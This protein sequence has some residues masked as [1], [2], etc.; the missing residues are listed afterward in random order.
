MKKFTTYLMALVLAMTATAAFAQDDD[1][2]VIKLGNA[3][4]ELEVGQQYVMQSVLTG[5]YIYPMEGAKEG[6]NLWSSDFALKGMTE[7][8]AQD[9]FVTLEKVDV[10]NLVFNIKFQTS[11]LYLNLGEPDDYSTL[12]ATA[13]QVKLYPIDGT[14]DAFSMSAG[15]GIHNYFFTEE[16]Q[17]TPCQTVNLA[18]EGE[19]ITTLTGFQYKFYLVEYVHQSEIG[20]FPWEFVNTQWVSSD[21]SRLE[22]ENIT[23]NDDNTVTV[24]ANE[25]GQDENGNPIFTN[26]AAL[27]NSA[28]TGITTADYYTT[29]DQQWLVV[30]GKDLSTAM[31]DSYLWWLNGANAGS[32]VPQ[33]YTV[34]LEDGQVLF[35]WDVTKTG[36]DANLKDDRN[37]QDGWTC[38]GL[39]PTTEDGTATFSDISFY[40]WDEAVAKYP[41]LASIEET[42]DDSEPYQFV[43]TD[44]TTSDFARLLE[45]N[46]TY[47]DDNTITAKASVAGYADDGSP[48]YTNNIGLGNSFGRAA[49]SQISTE[50][51]YT[52]IDQNW[53][54]VVGTDLSLTA[55]DSYLWWLNGAN[56]GTQEAAV[57]SITLE[58]GRVLVAWDVTKTEIDDRLG[59]NV[60]MQDGWT[61]FGVTPTLENGVSTISDI[62]FYSWKEAATKYPELEEVGGGADGPV[63]YEFV[64]TQW[65]TTDLGRLSQDQISY[66]EGENSISVDVTGNCNV[67]LGNSNQ[68]AQWSGITTIGYYATAEQHWLVVMGEELS[69]A[70]EDAYLWWLNGANNGSQV[71]PT[72]VVKRDDETVVFAWDLTQSGIDDNMQDEENTLEGWTAFGLTSINGSTVIY[73][74]SFYSWDEAVNKYYELEENDN[75]QALLETYAADLATVEDLILDIE[76]QVEEMEASGDYDQKTIEEMWDALEELYNADA[77]YGYIDGN[78]DSVEDI[79]AAIA[80]LE[81]VI[82]DT[83]HFSTG[84]SNVTT[85]ASADGAI[86]T[87]TG[88]RVSKMVKGVYIINGKKVLVK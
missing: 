29:L 63:P 12:S 15:E 30:V 69:V 31:G 16:D 87:L 55:T 86:Y 46:I 77:D 47:N 80:A 60:N 40:T 83:K 23:Y 6:A 36:L 20:P 11:G 85:S 61:C 66:N 9:F 70:L 10:D 64:N 74:I 75:I 2:M 68:Q 35:A 58:D 24:K 18:M 27:S 25:S 21:V 57:Y 81:A 67:A 72:I 17:L 42:P 7:E 51:Y 41:E 8:E 82:E 79:K 28:A 53:F 48:I 50:N 33:T 22:N 56:H 43:N 45:D 59:D 62:S 54:I 71:P 78:L 13:S 84:I 52:T 88:V 1:P 14:D 4:T 38:F 26:N 5:Y 73:D 44:W 32:S 65:V 34:E 37:V 76:E 49:F 39:T 19:E 3:V